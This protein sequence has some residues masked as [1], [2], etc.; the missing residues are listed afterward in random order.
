MMA[1]KRSYLAPKL[2]TV[3]A[4]A[5]IAATPSALVEVACPQ[6]SANSTACETPGNVQ[7]NSSPP[8]QTLPPQYDYLGGNG[9][10]QTSAAETFH[11]EGHHR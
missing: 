6:L 3:A 2:L 10:G 1:I 11:H 8:V 5:S 7:I 4:A 9:H